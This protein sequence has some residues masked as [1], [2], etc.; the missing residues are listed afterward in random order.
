MLNRYFLK[1]MQIKFLGFQHHLTLFE[2]TYKDA[3]NHA[4]TSY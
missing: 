2:L 3:S 1:H 4:R